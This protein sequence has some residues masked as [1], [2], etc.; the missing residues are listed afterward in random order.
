MLS[1]LSRRNFLSHS[2]QATFA[3]LA[4]RALAAQ[5]AGKR[6]NILFAISDDQS[7]LHASAYG[8]RSLSTPAFDRVA[9][10]GALFNNAFCPAPQCSPC[11]AATLTG[12]NIWQI[13][14][15]GTHASSFP[16]TFAVYPELLEKAGYHVGLTGKG[17]GPGNWKISGRTRNPAGESYVKRKLSPPTKAISANDYAGNFEDFLKARPN[18]APFCFWYGATEPHRN[19][20]P[21][22]GLKSGKKLEDVVVPPFLPDTPEIR[23]DILDYCL[24]IEW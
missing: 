6:P 21:G 16:A 2:A 11:R 5:P 12:M 14:E 22:S 18:G 10:E 17:W 23:S 13:E 24:E 1:H 3:L 7:W 9:R 8:C 20:E 19:Y 15:A 4:S